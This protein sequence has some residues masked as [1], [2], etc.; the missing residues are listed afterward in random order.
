MSTLHTVEAGSTI[1]RIIGMFPKEEEQQIRIRLS[2]TLRWVISQRLVPK[3]GGGRIALIEIMVN[4]MRVEDAILNG[5]EEGKTFYEIITGGDAYGMWTFDQHIM[6]LYQE[7][8]ITEETAMTAAS[9]RA[10]VGRGIDN[11]KSGK[12]EKT[13][14][15][16][17]LAMDEEAYKE[18]GNPFAKRKRRKS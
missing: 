8:T 9:R 13:T 7:G 6:Q 4:N 2:N 17:G 1:N 14:D 18:K 3:V 5:E 15:I 10:I 12:G 11:I 16:E